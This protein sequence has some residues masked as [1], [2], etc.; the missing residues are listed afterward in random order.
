VEAPARRRRWYDS[1]DEVLAVLL[2]SESDVDDLVPTL[3][4]YQIEWNKI[5]RRMLAAGW[6]PGEGATPEACAAALGGGGEE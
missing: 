6:P 5:R 4:A 3:V 2:A 1:G